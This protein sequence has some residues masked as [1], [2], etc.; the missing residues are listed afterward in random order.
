MYQKISQYLQDDE[1]INPWPDLM[2]FILRIINEKPKHILIPGLIASAYGGEESQQVMAN[3]ALTLLFGAIVSVDSILDGDEVGPMAE[4]S[5]G[6]L[7][8]MSLGLAGWAA[9]V[10][11]QLSDRPRIYKEGIE[12]I[13][14]LLYQVSF[15]QALD[16]GNPETEE[17]Y[18]E[19]AMMKSGAFF[20]GAFTLGGL[21]GGA[22]AADLTR[23]SALGQYYGVMLQIHD[24]LRDALEVPANSDWLNGRYTLPILFAHLVDHPERE[25]FEALRMQVMDAQKLEEV[26]TILVRSGALSYGLY[27]IQQLDE[28]VALEMEGLSTANDHDLRRMFTEL[29]QPVEQL[30]EAVAV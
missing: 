19:L 29:V 27:Q 11:R 13:S 10:L 12:T 23:L 3:A 1:F 2:Q 6:E 26:Q 4:L 28:Q 20:S 7:S 22:S 25:R 9:H 8:N 30:L 15:G 14:R 5:G 18:W 24:D 16:S 21:V 17:A